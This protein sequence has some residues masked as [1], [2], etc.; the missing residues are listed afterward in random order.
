MKKLTLVRCLMLAAL[1]FSS[2]ASAQSRIDWGQ[3]W[4]KELESNPL[5]LS[6]DKQSELLALYRQFNYQ[7]QFV[8]WEDQHKIERLGQ[9]QDLVAS[10]GINPNDF[11][12][13]QIMNISNDSEREVR[14]MLEVLRIAKAVSIGRISHTQVA[15][16]LKPNGK[17]NTYPKY[18][19]RIFNNFHNVAKLIQSPSQFTLD[20]MAPKHEDYVML[21][22][23]LALHQ[24]R[25]NPTMKEKIVLSMEKLRWLPER[26]RISRYAIVNTSNTMMNIYDPLIPVN[27]PLAKP[28]RII[29]GVSHKWTPSMPTQL[30][31]VVT[32]PYWNVAVNDML[33]NNDKLPAIHS[34]LA[35]GGVQGVVNYLD[36]KNYEVLSTRPENDGEVLD[37][38]LV[39]WALMVPGV[40]P[41]V[42]LRQK[43]GDSN[44][45][46][47]VK[48]FLKGGQDIFMHDTN[49]RYLFDS[50][51]RHHSSGCIRLS[52][53][54]EFAEYL[55]K[56]TPWTMEA[57]LQETTLPVFDRKEKWNP[58]SGTAFDVFTLHL[59]AQV[60][61][62]ELI[63]SNDLYKEDQALKDGLK[64][65]GY[66]ILN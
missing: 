4:K 61:N 60:L 5:N 66:S 10:H 21:K 51:Q 44:A 49:Q 14:M 19:N 54:L 52:L 62:N 12:L 3:V 13:K 55:L 23:A 65:A 6:A 50:D 16:A 17:P 24:V 18:D 40:D 42:R 39:D 58:V 64:K 30:T 43:A 29:T 11:A 41:G 7:P 31:S 36:Q 45:L 35:E 33:W 57:I 56:G 27:S 59:T 22:S 28:F 46:G 1:S 15:P 37:P 2:V 9:I 32:N 20:E 47:V 26:S 53:P 63:L 25:T 38:T 48:F 8:F 34:A